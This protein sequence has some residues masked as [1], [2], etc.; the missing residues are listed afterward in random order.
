M[1]RNKSTARKED[2][3]EKLTLAQL[4][5]LIANAAWRAEN[6]SNAGLRKSAF[7]RLVWLESQRERLHGIAAPNRR[8]PY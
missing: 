4:D 3:A 5:K 6:M 1:G 7:K 8:S 2:E